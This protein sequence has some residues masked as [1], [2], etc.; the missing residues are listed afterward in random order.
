MRIITQRLILREI[1]ESDF[2]AL[3]EIY[4]D[5]QARQYEQPLDSPPAEEDVRSRIAHILAEQAEQPRRHYRLA[6]TIPPEDRLRGWVSLKPSNLSYG[7]WEVGW[8]L[9]RS[10]WGQGYATEAARALMRFAFE[11]LNAH[12]VIAFCHAGNDASV[13]VMKRLGMKYEGCTRKTRWIN[14]AWADELI[15]AILEE[16]FWENESAHNPP[17]TEK[18]PL[19]QQKQELILRIRSARQK[20]EALLARLPPELM[21]KPGVDGGWSV[22]DHLAHLAEWARCQAGL[23]DGQTWHAALGVEEDLF[24]QGGIDA[25]NAAL[26]LRSR[27][28]SLEDVLGG[29]RAAHEAVLERIEQMPD[30]ALAQ[31]TAFPDPE[32]R[33]TMLEAI[34]S[35][36][37]EHDLEHTTWIA[38]LISNAD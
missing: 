18:A 33:P 17:Q 35:N 14:N 22:K 29:F 38:E 32:A 31:V 25:V 34:S 2:S 16:E 27:G 19:S 1:E 10:A 12:R 13:R 3:Y 30:D 20:L 6:V 5:R 15:Y 21:E 23:I 8:S 28:R 11:A 24:R 7:E 37:F 4:N 26:C 36:T 9:E